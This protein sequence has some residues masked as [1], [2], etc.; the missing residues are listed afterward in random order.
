MKQTRILLAGILGGVVFFICGAVEHMVFQWVDSQIK[1]LPSET[2]MV[3][4]VKG[5]KLE[6][7]IYV[8]P[9]MQAPLAA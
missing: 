7:G 9:N 1:R 5:Q 3:E 6:S 2:D 4:F 8:Y